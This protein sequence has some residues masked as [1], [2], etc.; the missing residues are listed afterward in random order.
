MSGPPDEGAEPAVKRQ[1]GDAGQALQAHPPAPAAAP[2]A[3]ADA[4]DVPSEDLLPVSEIHQRRTDAMRCVS[5]TEA[6]CRSRSSVWK[7][8]L[9]EAKQ[10]AKV[11][12]DEVTRLSAE[13]ALE[14]YGEAEAGMFVPESPPVVRLIELSTRSPSEEGVARAV[15]KAA[16]QL[17][18]LK[19]P[20]LAHIAAAKRS[21]DRESLRRL[22]GE[23]ND[24]AR[25]ARLVRGLDKC[26]GSRLQHSTRA[27]AAHR[28][29]TAVRSI[30]TSLLRNVPPTRAGYDKVLD[31]YRHSEAA[32]HS[33]GRQLEGPQHFTDIRRNVAILEV[34]DASGVVV[35]N[36]FAV[37][38]EATPGIGP[39]AAF[40]CGAPPLFDAIEAEDGLGETY[41][42]QFDAEYKLVSKF[43]METLG[44]TVHRNSEK[45]AACDFAG[46]IVLWSKKPLCASCAGVIREQLPR[47]VQKATLTVVVDDDGT[48]EHHKPL[49]PCGAAG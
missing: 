21:S 31:F 19:A 7:S 12:P 36:A 17:D 16:G 20:L 3:A 23:L 28:A 5:E 13:R 15:D 2:T 41:G 30:Q 33:F 24:L 45:F 49:C 25:R 32:E 38:G 35:F 22:G 34:R 18:E 44:L 11:P 4:P 40:P 27:L 26:V 9:E 48:T 42:R 46:T 10:C 37:S 43:C 47:Y 1:R 6:L 8:R 14:L 39:P 29:R